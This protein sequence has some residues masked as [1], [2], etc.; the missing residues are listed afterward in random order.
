MF[1][2][3]FTPDKHGFWYSI[4][5]SIPIRFYIEY[6]AIGVGGRQEGGILEGRCISSHQSFKR[7]SF[8]VIK[9]GTADIQITHST[10]TKRNSGISSAKMGTL[11]HGTT[12]GPIASSRQWNLPMVNSQPSQIQGNDQDNDYGQEENSSSTDYG[13]SY[14]GF[15]APS[16]S[17]GPFSGD[18]GFESGYGQGYGLSYGQDGD[19]GYGIDTNYGQDYGSEID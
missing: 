11:E 5:S 15:N 7:I 14:S 6:W 12:H 4:Q 10:R 13:I 19:L 9:I 2:V 8:K 18:Y 17:F 3:F 1:Y 16:R